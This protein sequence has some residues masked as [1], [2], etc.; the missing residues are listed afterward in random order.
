MQCNLPD[1]ESVR[2]GGGV[3]PPV[4]HLHRELARAD[5]VREWVTQLKR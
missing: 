4:A 3:D 1:D 2:R 5:P